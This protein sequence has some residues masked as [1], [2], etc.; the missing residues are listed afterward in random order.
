MSEMTREQAVELARKECGGDQYMFVS[1]W[2]I[3][4][5]Q[6]ASS[7]G[8]NELWEPVAWRFG[9]SYWPTRECMPVPLQAEAEPLYA[10]P[11]RQAAY[12]QGIAANSLDAR[13]PVAWRVRFH[14]DDSLAGK[15]N[16]R[17]WVLLPDRPV[18]GS[19]IESEP[20]YTR[21]LVPLTL[22]ECRTLVA[23]HFEHGELCGDDLRLIRA[24]ENH[25]GI[26]G[27]QGEKT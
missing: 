6:A 18:R 25:H 21:P 8:L 22:T 9:S 2:V 5:I 7:R 19:A 3:R 10:S 1:E 17:P 12:A 24:V 23:A 20:L 4:A 14:T 16:V 26:G 11:P 13:E 27:T 15:P